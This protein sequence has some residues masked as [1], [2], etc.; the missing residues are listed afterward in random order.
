MGWKIAT[1]AGPTALYNEKTDAAIRKVLDQPPPKGFAR[2]SGPLI[3]KALDNVGVQYVW[4]SLRKH[5]IDFGRAQELVR[6]QRSGFLRQGR[7]CGGALNGA[8]EERDCS[9]RR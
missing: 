7:R 4:R 3:A 8:T 1:A 9:L 6:E 2:W 5:K